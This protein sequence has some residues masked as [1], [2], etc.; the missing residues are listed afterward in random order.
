MKPTFL[1]ILVLLLVA[2]SNT[3][4]DPMIPVEITHIDIPNPDYQGHRGARGLL[5]ENTIPSFIRALELGVTTLE[6]DLVVS[7][8]SQLVVSH[9]PWFNH[10]ISSHPDGRP[11]AQEESKQLN[12]FMMEY[13]TIK[14]YD[15]GQRGNPRFPDQIPTPIYK[16]TL[17]AVV[18]ATEKWLTDHNQPPVWYNVETKSDPREYDNYYPQPDTFAQLLAAEILRLGI[19]DRVVV[20]SFDPN[21]LTAMRHIQPNIHLALLIEN[22]DSLTDN[23]DR[24]GFLPEI[25]SPYYLLVDSVMVSEV[26]NLGMRLIPWTINDTAEI[27]RLLDLGV[28]GVIT[29]YPNRIP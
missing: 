27:Q 17:A 21:T 1:I 10:E 19:Q 2:C 15:V 11:V 7:Q 24:L 13:A 8:D 3:K 23:L 5:P 29:D 18:E 16:P 28:D 9:E 22:Q 4:S 12:I 14:T 25:Y 26:H 20:Q 6:L